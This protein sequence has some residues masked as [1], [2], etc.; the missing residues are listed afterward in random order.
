MAGIIHI[1]SW[2]GDET[3]GESKTWLFES[4]ENQQFITRISKE[5]GN[6]SFITFERLGSLSGRD[7]E[8]KKW[9]VLVYKTLLSQTNKFSSQIY[10]IPT[11]NTVPYLIN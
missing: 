1:E 7:W 2:K 5:V 3:F 11:I 4:G 6:L 9:S 10:Y 8:R